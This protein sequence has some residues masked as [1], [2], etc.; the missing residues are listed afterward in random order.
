MD[1]LHNKE[2]VKLIKDSG[3]RSARLGFHKTFVSQAERS[4]ERASKAYNNNQ[5]DIENGEAAATILCC[6]AACE[7]IVSEFFEHLYFVDGE[8]PIEIE[9]IR[10]QQN[11]LIQWKEIVNYKKVDIDLSTSIEYNHLSCLIKV[12]DTV[13]H[14]NSRAF[15]DE[16]FPPNISP[17]IINKIIPADSTRGIDWMDGIL[18][19]KVAQWAISTTKN[20]INL[21]EKQIEIKC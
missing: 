12:R 5:I 14:R 4:S 10:K 6:S 21:V 19:Y 3:I 2:F 20:W 8:L 16:E 18:T 9:K 17:C 7:A 11:L 13:A 1:E 15:K